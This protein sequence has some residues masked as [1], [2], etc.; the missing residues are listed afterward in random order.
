V[1]A[2]Y[3]QDSI[4]RLREA[5]DVVE[6]IGGR[7][8]LRRVGT[9]F[10][11]LCPFHD[12]RTPSFSVE[13]SKGVYH[14]FGCG[15]GGDAIGF[16]QET[17]ALPFVE[18]V[19][20]LAERYN[21][22]LKRENED[23]AEEE[24]RRRRG[25]LLALLE[26]TTAFYEK[27]L[28]S[29]DDARVARDYLAGRGLSEE[30]L[31]AYRVGWS[32]SGW[33]RLLTGAQRDGFGFEELIAAGLAQRKRSGEGGVD[34]FRERIMFPLADS[35][36]R[37]L[38]FGARTLRADEP[39]KYINTAE[40]EVYHKGRQLF[41]IDKARV[42]AAK[43][44]R[45][46]V[47]EGYTDVLALHQ[48]GVAETVAIMGTA[49]TEHQLAELARAAGGD[50]VVYL[51]L[52]ADSSGQQAMLRAAEL[53]EQR[54][55]ELRVVQ[56]PEGVDP[57]ELVAADGADAIVGRLEGALSVLEFAV[58]RVLA[59]AQLGTPEGRD[60]ALGQARELI[61]E[62]PAQSARRDHLVQLVA[63]RLD[64]PADYVVTAVANAPRRPRAAAPAAPAPSQYGDPGPEW[65]GDPG[66]E[67]PPEVAPAAAAGP[68]SAALEAE[69]IFLAL[70]LG[71]GQRG[72]DQLERLTPD[73]LS[74]AVLQR[75]RGHLIEHFEDPLADL[76]P[77][78]N[79]LAALV[80][81]IALRAEDSEPAG[82]ALLRM[83]YLALELRRV[84]REIRH[85]RQDGDLARQSELA[86][87]RQQVRR[88]MDAVMGE[89]G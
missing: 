57:A 46:V 45:V 61:A 7:T 69:R 15:V 68:G 81:G 58:R 52:D 72:R 71:A 2:R 64:V 82:D 84:D 40:N 13:A 38:G 21:V 33:D 87:A 31:R 53:A 30:T 37:V 65:A 76:D 16:V 4:E 8:D 74:S 5:V 63:D 34:R 24:R 11:G 80:A 78:D 27:F 66:P 35:R 14:C 79:E 59:E 77:A 9:R 44:R 29:S 55:V 26:R 6:L 48:A 50:G 32:P 70:C 51:A 60:R 3:T 19:E 54:D 41:G 47:V 12:E 43:S 18:A 39:A 28:W 73:H 75:V 67:R 23:P 1:P 62:A 85:A 83:S 49:L 22:E 25:R 36:G 89:V 56:M 86:S 17:E 20:L 42:A 10:V 88:D